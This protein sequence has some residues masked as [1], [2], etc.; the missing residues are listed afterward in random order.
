[1][2]FEFSIVSWQQTSKE[3]VTAKRIAWVIFRSLY[4]LRLNRDA[5]AQ[6]EC[7]HK[8][9]VPFGYPLSD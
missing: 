2:C 5:R 1:M 4:T 3:G 9:G 6:C 7:S 8:E